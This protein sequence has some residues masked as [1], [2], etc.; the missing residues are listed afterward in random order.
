MQKLIIILAVLSLSL[1]ACST[2]DTPTA[3]V[4]A[5]IK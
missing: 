2:M 3:G 4:C 1:V 5:S